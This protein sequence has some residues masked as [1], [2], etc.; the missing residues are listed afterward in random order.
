MDISDGAAARAILPIAKSSVCRL[1][2]I[3]RGPC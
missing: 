1:S 2:F 3:V